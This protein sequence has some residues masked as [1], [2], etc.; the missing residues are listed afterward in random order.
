[1]LKTRRQKKQLLGEINGEVLLVPL[2]R[3]DAIEGLRKSSACNAIWHGGM[4]NQKEV[5]AMEVAKMEMLR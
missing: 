5:G 1:M 4:S 2:R 3:T